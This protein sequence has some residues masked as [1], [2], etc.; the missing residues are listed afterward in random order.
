MVVLTS[1]LRACGAVLILLV[2]YSVDRIINCK[3]N[4]TVSMI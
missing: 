3:Y 2:G 4:A 1:E